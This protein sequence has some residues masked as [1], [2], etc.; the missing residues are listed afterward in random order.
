MRRP[1]SLRLL[2]RRP[3]YCPNCQNRHHQ[4]CNLLGVPARSPMGW[5][6]NPFAEEVTTSPESPSRAHAPFTSF[7]TNALTVTQ[8]VGVLTGAAALSVRWAGDRVQHGAANVDR[9]RA[10]NLDR[11]APLAIGLIRDEGLGRSGSVS[12]DA[13]G[14]A[15]GPACC[16]KMETSR[17][18]QSPTISTSRVPNLDR[19]AHDRRV[20]STTNGR[21]R[22]PRRSPNPIVPS[23]PRGAIAGKLHDT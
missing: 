5:Y 17:G 7:A 22:P 18:D 10:R 13:A 4:H 11:V 19:V 6:L 16:T 2:A 1:T 14:A 15:I 8:G 20:S 9:R 12:V 3:G 21:G 23:C